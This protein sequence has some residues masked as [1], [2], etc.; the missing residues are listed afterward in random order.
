MPA[1]R[2]FQA[3]Y[4][5]ARYFHAAGAVAEA[6]IQPTGGWDI[7]ETAAERAR[8]VQRERERMGIIPRQ[9]PEI[10]AKVAARTGIVPPPAKAPPL[11]PPPE[12]PD[13]AAIEGA[14]V[15][16]DE[17]QARAARRLRLEDDSLAV[18]LLLAA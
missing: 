13:A 1:A 14:A 8:R 4:I 2:Y 3:H 17:A 15:I 12:M 10:P 6:G 5:D 16:M 9:E 18:L 7:G 11:P